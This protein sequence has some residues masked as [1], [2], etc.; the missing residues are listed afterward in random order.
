[1]LK[2]LNKKA[3]HVGVILSIVIFVGFLLF[4]FII[5][6]P[7][8]RTGKDPS[9]II[10]SVK[11]NFKEQASANLTTLI[12]TNNSFPSYGCLKIDN[13]EI[14]TSGLNPYVEDIEGNP[15]YFIESENYLEVDLSGNKKTYVVYY[16]EEEF[17]E[18]PAGVCN[19]PENEE[20]FLNSLKTK[21]EIF[22]S[23]IL[24]LIFLA[25]SDYENIRELLA[26]PIDVEMGFGFSYENGTKIET[27]DHSSLD[28]FVDEEAIDY[29]S[30]EGEVRPG[31][32][33]I[34]LWD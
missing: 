30:K 8:V 15:V 27:H 19:S 16:S 29:I 9:S 21:Q 20:Y 22:E 7:S 26:I 17:S 31:T 5:L 24:Q 18:P 32:L 33:I 3:S 11:L 12:I 34:K 23:R 6:D 1:M 25:E 10:N 13:S 4:M 28:V 2:K 14:G